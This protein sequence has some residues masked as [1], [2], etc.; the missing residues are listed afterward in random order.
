VTLTPP[1]VTVV[2]NADQLANLTKID[3]EPI[4]VTGLSSEETR[5]VLLVMPDGVAPLDQD[6]VQVVIELRPVT[7]TRS[8]DVGLRL[9]GADPALAYTL[10]TD[11]VL[12]VL[13]GSTA[14]LDRLV[15]STLVADLD[16][17]D[18][19]VGTTSVRVTAAPRDGVTLVSSSPAEVAVTV[20]AQPS[21]PPSIAP[22]GVVPS[23][24]PGG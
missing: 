23:A 8:F 13:G 1:T 22:S 24:S 20:T 9:I 4:P 21:P 6:T 14:D 3:T 12:I 5:E 7:A 11:R 19:G 2:G 10:G 16:V 18:L 17:T 15:G